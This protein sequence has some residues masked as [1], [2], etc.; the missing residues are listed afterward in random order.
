MANAV[1]CIGHSSA[2]QSPFQRTGIVTP[3]HWNGPYKMATVLGVQKLLFLGGKMIGKYSSFGE[4]RKSVKN[5]K[6]TPPFF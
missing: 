1:H 6:K 3:V 5:C 4:P 2:L